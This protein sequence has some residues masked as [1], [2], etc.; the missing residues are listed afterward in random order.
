[1]TANLQN[2]QFNLNC[3]EKK[4]TILPQLIII[5]IS[6]PLHALTCTASM[7]NGI[8]DNMSFLASL[9]SGLS[10]EE[11]ERC[12]MSPEEVLCKKGLYRLLTELVELWWYTPLPLVE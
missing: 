11:E 7:C 9:R 8:T 2:N 10:Q 4:K 12:P 6:F 3:K 5:I 1:M